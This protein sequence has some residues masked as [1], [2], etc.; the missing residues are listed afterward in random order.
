MTIFEVKFLTDE[1]IDQEVVEFLREQGFDVVDVKEAGWFGWMDSD[2][3]DYAS[4]E[5][6]VMISQDSDFGTLV[7]RD[8]KPFYGI[9]YLRPGHASPSVHID[10]LRAVLEA[11]LDF[12]TSFLLVAE[13]TGQMVRL[14]LR[15]L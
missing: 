9:L 12:A 4:N 8:Q 3:L 6:R 1:N 13:N 15:Q 10:S 2:L 14:R 5:K 7:F 11:N